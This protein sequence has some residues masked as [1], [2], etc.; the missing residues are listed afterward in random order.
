MYC[1]YEKIILSMGGYILNK[2]K[3]IITIFVV[4]IIGI[5]VT[6]NYINGKRALYT[7]EINSYNTGR[8]YGYTIYMDGTLK[9]N[10]S[11]KTEKELIKTKISKEELRKLKEL[12]NKLEDNYQEKD[13]EYTIFDA[14]TI[15]ESMY[16]QRKSK[17][18]KL[19]MT[20]ATT[21]GY[22]DS[23]VAEEILNLTDSIHKKYIK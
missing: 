15:Y 4:C 7:K 6:I 19:E 1:I 13:S 3:I 5:I 8:F 12:A 11:K 23:D 22:N 18:I 10:N 16:S 2:K 14:A 21:Y 20:S 17:W 9:E